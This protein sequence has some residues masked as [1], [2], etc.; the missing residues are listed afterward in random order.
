MRDQR[1]VA[2]HRGG[3]LKKAQHQQLIIWS[4]ACVE[5][6]LSQLSPDIDDRLKYALL[7]AK[8]WATGNATV[9]GAR[10]ASVGAHAAAREFSNP[11]E[12]AISR[13]SGHAV[14]TAH[15]ADH[16][17]GGTLYSL[18]A[19]KLAGKSVEA[20]RTWQNQQLPPEIKELVLS[21][22]IEKEHHFKLS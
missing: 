22:R 2:E 20:E 11:I 17:L 3:P 19:V 13:A 7:I 10:K 4:C 16:S 1:W 12:I 18:K 9:G 15:M 14:A 5:H 21:T 6:V 8:Q